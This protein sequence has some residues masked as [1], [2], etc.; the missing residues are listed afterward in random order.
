MSKNNKPVIQIEN[1]NFHYGEN[2]V[3]KNINLCIHD[4]DYLVIVGPNGGG[5]TT[6][7][8]LILGLLESNSGS[9][10]LF[11]G[12]VKTNCSKIGYVPQN[13]NINMN[14]PIKVKDVIEMGNLNS[15]GNTNEF[16]R[17]EIFNILDIKKLSE[18]RIGNLS[19]GQ[20]QRVL[21]ARALMG[22][23]S[24]LFLDEPVSG[25]DVEGQKKIYEI[26]MELNKKL[27]ILTVSHDMNF[28]LRYA[29]SVA[30]VRQS[31]CFHNAPR[32]TPEMF[33]IIYDCPFEILNTIMPGEFEEK[34]HDHNH[35]ECE[36]ENND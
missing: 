33:K 27:T 6:L 2:H 32:L 30:V 15:H 35:C 22:N 23:P 21:V 9:I 13:T 4:L 11:G 16:S 17:E 3:L 7:L 8:K 5:K 14:F 24:A 26:L 20:R 25:I 10:K 1:L 29:K 36:G 19:G 31:L 28:I 34:S 18:E 12:D